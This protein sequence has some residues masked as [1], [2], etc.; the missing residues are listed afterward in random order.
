[1][2]VN[3]K[4]R[5]RSRSSSSPPTSTGG[6]MQQ[7]FEALLLAPFMSTGGKKMGSLL[8]KPN[9]DLDFMAELLEAGKVV[10]VI[11]QCY[12]LHEIVDA[13]RYYDEGHTQGK[14]IITVAQDD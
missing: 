10:P 2:Q 8:V 4:I 1:M 3:R 12:P 11:D 9:K 5:V 7:T 13:I 14:I 6:A